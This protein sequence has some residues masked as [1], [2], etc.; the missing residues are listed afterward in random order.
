MDILFVIVGFLG[1]VEVL[2]GVELLIERAAVRAAW[3]RIARQRRQN[4][5]NQHGGS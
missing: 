4:W 2:V 1:A 5:E 3:Q